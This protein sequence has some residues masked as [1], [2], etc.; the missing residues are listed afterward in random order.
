VGTK[1]L[2]STDTV[3]VTGTSV[4]GG[5]EWYSVVYQYTGEPAFPAI[6]MRHNAAGLLRRSS[7]TSQPFFVMKNPVEVGTTWTVSWVTE[8]IS[9]TSRLTVRSVD[10]TVA[11]PA[12]TYTNCMKIEDV[13]AL[14]GQEDDVVTYWYAPDVG[15]VR[16]EH[17]VGTFLADQLELTSF[18]PATLGAIR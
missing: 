3:T 7:A 18:T 10:D 11:T 5:Q 17:H 12:G 4:I 8:G 14:S 9:Y 2:T 6:Y 13:L 15:E 16:E 1:Q